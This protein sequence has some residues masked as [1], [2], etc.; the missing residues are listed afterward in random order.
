MPCKELIPC[1]FCIVRTPSILWGPNN[2]KEQ[3]SHRTVTKSAI[4]TVPG[5]GR[6]TCLLHVQSRAWIC[7]HATWG[8]EKRFPF[9]WVACSSPDGTTQKCAAEICAAA[10]SDHNGATQAQIQGFSGS[11]LL[12][13]MGVDSAYLSVCKNTVKSHALFPVQ[14]QMGPFLGPWPHVC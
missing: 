9:P 14:L 11:F 6:P 5:I 4:Q 10:P 3:T 12:P 13:L 2:V 7:C 8:K 1:R